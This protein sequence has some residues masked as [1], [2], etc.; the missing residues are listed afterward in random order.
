MLQRLKHR[1][2][3]ILMTVD[4][5]GG[6]WQYAMGLAEQM[7]TAGHA[8]VFAG[9]GPVPSQQQRRQAEQIGAVVWLETPPDWMATN[10]VELL[11]LAGELETLVRDHAIDLVHLNAPSQAAGL[12]VPCPVVVVSHSCVVSWFH[13][14]RGSKLPAP[15]AWHEDCNRAG[16]ERADVVIAP[17]GSHA[18]SLRACYGPLPRLRVVHNG[19]PSVPAWTGRQDTIF[20]AGR[21]WDAGKNGRVLDA[22]AASCMWPVLCAGSLTGPNG[23]GISFHNAIPLGSISHDETRLRMGTAGIFVSPSIYE[24]FGLAALEAAQVGTPLILADIPTYRELWSG[25]ALFFAPDDPAALADTINRL[26]TSPPMR[27]RLGSAAMRRSRRYTVSKQAAATS[28]AY[29][30]ASAIHAGGH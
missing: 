5:V 29:E 2:H 30:Q 6:A 20:A 22:A 24:P 12:R 9:L 3:R 11:R 8:I 7:V 4:A 15:W 1:P 23:D 28:L 14:V 17:S 10:S 26:S 18:A 13:V 27:A 19:V 21:W 16:L 25:A